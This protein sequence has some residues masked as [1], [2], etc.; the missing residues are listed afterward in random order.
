MWE[1]PGGGNLYTE[2]WVREQFRPYFV[3]DRKK[4]C[5][6][7]YSKH[8]KRP[9]LSDQEDCHEGMYQWVGRDIWNLKLLIVYVGY[10]NESCFNEVDLV[11]FSD[12]FWID[13]TFDK[14]GWRRATRSSKM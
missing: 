8:R 11:V 13:S 1:R 14:K 4:Q 5:K 12:L 3:T 6:W 7:R 2:V 9:H 10:E